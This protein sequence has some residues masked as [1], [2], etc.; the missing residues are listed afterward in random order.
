MS[1]KGTVKDKVIV[2]DSEAPWPNGMRVFVSASAETGGTE[3]EEHD[4][5]VD[6]LYDGTPYPT[7]EEG[8]AELLARMDSREPVEMS[9]EEWAAWEKQRQKERAQQK[10]MVR[11]IWEQEADLI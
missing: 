7:T 10:E 5:I 2:L 11:Q 4:E 6:R 8:L 1:I 3:D 9:D